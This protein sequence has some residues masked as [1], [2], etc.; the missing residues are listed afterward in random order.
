V[1][2]GDT[3]MH[4]NIALPRGFQLQ[5]YRIES[6]LGAGGFGM[7]YLATDANLNMQVAIKEYLPTDL[8]ARGT[9]QS[10]HSRSDETLE[11]F[12][13]GL[14][15]FL[16]ESRTLASFHHPNIV[17]VKRF[18][19]A[20]QTAYMVMEF[21]A[22]ES[23]NDWIRSRRPIPAQALTRMALALLDGMEVVHQSGYLHRDI[24]PR[25]IFLRR[26][27][28][29]VLL[30][31]GSA[32]SVVA[33]TER[34]SIV[35]P[36]YAPLEQYH[37]HGN[38]GPWTDVYALGGVMYWAVTGRRPMEA[39]ARVPRDPMPAAVRAA[40][41]NHYPRALLQA[42]DWALAPSERARPQSAAA[43]HQILEAQLEPGT[44]RAP[45]IFAER[46]RITDNS[47][48]HSQPS[49]IVGFHPVALK[50][51]ASDLAPHLGPVAGAFVRSTAKKSVTLRQLVETLAAD[52]IDA[53]AR[54]KFVQVH[55]PAQDPVASY[56][57]RT[58]PTHTNAAAS[59]SFPPPAVFDAALLARAETEL[60]R[61]VGAVAKAIVRRAAAK[62][63]SE[64]ELCKL[65]ANEIDDVDQRKGFLRKVLSAPGGS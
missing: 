49:S 28:T 59:V 39:T 7:T 40:D 10:I 35:S 19:E 50:K 54:K 62:A 24:K 41:G 44:E 42:I 46:S 37:T 55:A 20:N 45:S 6:V 33:N 1:I 52:I 23:L 22:G 16:D 57:E 47:A 34:T 15:R 63:R 9:D 17:R 4:D 26:S 18:F 53:A 51:M 25:N 21:V 11:K 61:H 60:A 65:L 58:Q 38:Q 12:A 5:E 48:I 29:P 30:D 64:P 43:L 27:G 56:E 13:N 2:D 14:A 31:F 32:R 8:A 3:T 36:G